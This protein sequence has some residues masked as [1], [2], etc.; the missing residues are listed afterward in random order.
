MGMASSGVRFFIFVEGGPGL[1]GKSPPPI[2]ILCGLIEKPAC[3]SGDLVFGFPG[4]F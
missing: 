4:L 3:F 1:G 2:E